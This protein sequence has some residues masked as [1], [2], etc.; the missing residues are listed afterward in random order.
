[1]SDFLA[2]C[3]INGRRCCNGVR[4]DFS[5]KHPVSGEKLKC[6][7]WIKLGGMD[8]QTGQPIDHW[9]C[10]RVAL[11]MLLVE[12]S[13]Q[14]RQVAKSVDK[15]A[16]Q[17]NKQRAEFIGALPDEAREHLEKFGPL[18]LEELNGSH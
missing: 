17:V 10:A 3:P 11:P 7:E 8:P 14:Q 18:L 15:V 5:A 13:N 16:N 1:M 4:D 12:N 9:M 6:V 2:A